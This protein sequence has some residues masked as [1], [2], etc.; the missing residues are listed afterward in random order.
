ML[1]G[2]GLYTLQ[3][4]KGGKVMWTLWPSSISAGDGVSAYEAFPREGAPCFL[5]LAHFSLLLI[6]LRE[7][8]LPV[9]G[10]LLEDCSTS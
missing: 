1:P 7:E 8:I 6:L 3:C 2:T 4:K 10:Q 5:F 9:P